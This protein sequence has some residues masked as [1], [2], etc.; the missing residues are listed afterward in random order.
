MFNKHDLQKNKHENQ[1]KYNSQTY[2]SFLNWILP[3]RELMQKHF[4]QSW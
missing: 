2:T 3:L 4:G 1:H